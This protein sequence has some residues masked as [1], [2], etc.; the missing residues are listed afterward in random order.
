M[1]VFKIA[2]SNFLKQVILIL[3][4]K[5]VISLQNN[6]QE[7]AQTPQIGVDRHVIF[8]GDDFRSHVGGS[9]AESVDGGGRSGFQAETKI[10][11]F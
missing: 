9:A 5:R 3:G 4:P 2:L 7:Y 1:Y 6:E 10:D 8:F 11:Q